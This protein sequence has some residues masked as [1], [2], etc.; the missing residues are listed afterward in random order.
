MLGPT[1]RASG[2]GGCGPVPTLGARRAAPV[3]DEVSVLSRPLRFRSPQLRMIAAGLVVIVATCAVD[4]RRRGR[5][6]PRARRHARP[7]RPIAALAADAGLTV[8]RDVS[9][10]QC[11][12]R[13]AAAERAPTSACSA[14][15]TASRSRA[16]R[17]S[18]A[19]RVGEAPRA[20]RPAFYANTGNPG[21]D[22]RAALAARPDVAAGVRGVR[23]ELDRVFLRLRLERGVAVVHRRRPTPRSDLHHVDRANARRAPRTST[24]GSTSRR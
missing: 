16:T 4:H 9:F 24:G 7:A 10:P 5:P 15:T 13:A 8:A 19:A 1:G 11:K 20:A 17:A 21:P 23:P 3:S 14:R 12:R 22:A 18:S 2:R 6:P